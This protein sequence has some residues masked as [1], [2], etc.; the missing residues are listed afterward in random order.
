MRVMRRIALAVCAVACLG[1]SSALALPPVKHVFLIVLENKEY[2]QSFGPS[3]PATYISQTLAAQGQVLE[4]YHGTSHSSLGNY[5][6]LISGQAP[7]PETQANCTHGF[8]DVFPGTLTVDGQTLGSGCVY[9]SAVKTIVDQL[10]GAGRTWRAYMQD[11]G[12]APGMPQTCRHPAIGESD[13]TQVARLGDQYAMRHNPFVYFHSIIDDQQR[14]DTGVV[15]LDLLG[16]DLESAA[17]TPSLVFVTPNL[18]EDGHDAPCVDGRP[19]GLVSADAFVATWAPRITASPAYADGGLLVVLW[20]EGTGSAACCDEPSGPNTALPGKTG[21]GG[22]RTG[23]VVV[24]PFV[25]P[26]TRNSTPY[27][28]YALLRS[29]EDLFGLGHLGYAGAAGLRAFGADVF[30]APAVDAAPPLTSSAPPSDTSP[31]DVTPPGDATGGQ[32]GVHAACPQTKLPAA[33]HGRYPRG[34][35]LAAARVRRG[36]L[37]LTTRRA[38]R[39]AVR[40]AGAQIRTPALLRACQTIWIQL[41]RR[42]GPIVVAVGDRHGAERRVFRRM[43]QG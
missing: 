7:N 12:N 10:D 27:N 22:G 38:G 14:C 3:S 17:T 29:I 34:T 28:H 6:S 8:T 41:P 5:L 23:A 18:C 24:S 2:D 43:Q 13:T 30:T 16:P 40:V 26:G 19:G 31:T 4:Q 42:G 35:F 39:L 15:P 37:V 20:D 1:S 11:M 36:G 33:R 21:P 9:P 25:A 32:P